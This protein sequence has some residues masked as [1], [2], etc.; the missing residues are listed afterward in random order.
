MTSEIFIEGKR[1]DITADISSLLTFAIDDVKDFASRQTAFSKT[2][3][4]PGTANNNALFGNI[5]ETGSA[6]DYSPVQDNIGYNFNASKSA[7][8]LLFQDNMQTFKGTMRML[9]IVKDKKT[10]Q[11]EVA[12]NG[13]LTSLNVALSTGLIENLDFS[14]YDMDFTIANIVSSWDNPPG[15]GVYFP[16]ID[17]GTY[18]SDKHNWDVHTFR[19][20][21][22]AKE[23]IDKMFAAGNFRYDCALF[24]TSRFKSLVIPHNK[25]T[26]TTN[27][28]QLLSGS[29]ST[30]YVDPLDTSGPQ[31]FYNIKYDSVIG[32][33]FT[34]DADNKKFTYA[35]AISTTITINAA[36]TGTSDSGF[37]GIINLTVKK[38]GVV[39]FESGLFDP[40]ITWE[41]TIS[42]ATGDYLE[43]FIGPYYALDL[44][45][46]TFSI[47]TAAGAIP[48]PINIG[49]RIAINQSIPQNVRQVDFFVSIVKLF[50]LYVY[51][52]RFDERLIHI[53][54]F[55]D[56][57]S[58]D[59]SNSLDWT[60]KLDRDKPVRVKPMSELNSK[61]YNF[62]YKDDSDY[63]NSEYKK[64]YNQGY[65]SYIFD[66]QFEFASQSSSVDLIFASTPLVGYGGEDK[67]YPTI[68][69]KSGNTEENIDCV[70]RIMQSK[71]VTGV[72][73]WDITDDAGATVLGSYTSYGYAGH[74]DDPDNPDNDLNFGVL[75]ELFFVLSTGNLT[76]T[77][78]NIY[79]SSYMAEITDKDSKM[80]MG[81]FYLTPADIFNLDFSKYIYVDG[82]LFR[83]NKIADYNASKPNTCQVQLLKVINTLY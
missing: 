73:S 72:T 44:E 67:V 63:Y 82:V 83:L 17:Y 31:R 46:A 61:I 76:K 18:S 38:N 12:L 29:I 52:S 2:V 48:V 10:I 1:V 50:N 65:G 62:L 68:F 47:T 64:R 70:I 21:L 81:Q 33:G 53:T 71:K 55:V 8:C 80:L 78:F 15:S 13:E 28:T 77:Q 32:S 42:I 58:T 26:L 36:T 75:K 5:F 35:G 59:S 27:N 49:D 23:Y 74:L 24:N 11:Y 69:K 66:S 22:Y 20:A 9:E 54:P 79:W 40:N 3:V 4:L 60:Y 45:T 14:A 39:A 37:L 51:E 41:T 16:L 43:F 57:Y 7:R 6:N 25:K 34:A 19:P 30:P 56:F